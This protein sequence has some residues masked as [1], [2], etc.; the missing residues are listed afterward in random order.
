M[1]DISYED[2][3]PELRRE[4]ARDKV[5]KTTFMRILIAALMIGLTIYLKMTGLAAVIMIA[6]AVYIIVSMIPVWAIVKSSLK[7]EDESP[8]EE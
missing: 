4:I 3:N 5:K 8:E 6:A 7:E 1:A 2:M